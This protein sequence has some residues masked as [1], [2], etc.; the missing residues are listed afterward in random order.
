MRIVP[1]TACGF[2]RSVQVHRIIC[3]LDKSTAISANPRTAESKPR[4]HRCSIT[5]FCNANAMGTL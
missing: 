4:P 2:R 3:C 1:I 5:C